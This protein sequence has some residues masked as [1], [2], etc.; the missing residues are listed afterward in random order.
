MPPFGVCARAQ[1]AYLLSSLRV[2]QV[3]HGLVRVDVRHSGD[4]VVV[5]RLGVKVRHRLTSDVLDGA[6]GT[7]TGATTATREAM[8]CHTYMY[9]HSTCLV[10]CVCVCVRRLDKSLW[11]C[12]NACVVCVCV[13][14]CGYGRPALRARHVRPARPR[15][16]VCESVCARVSYPDARAAGSPP[17]GCRASP[18]PSACQ[19]A[20]SSIPCSV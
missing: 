7:G 11:L 2:G 9:T 12:A 1:S 19:K 15:A 17:T 10:L 5:H 20:S 6:Q 3:V 13:C 16:P 8:Q 14:L 18:A 4:D